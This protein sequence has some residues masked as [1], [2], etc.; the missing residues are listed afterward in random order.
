MAYSI[1]KSIEIQCSKALK[2]I[3][4]KTEALRK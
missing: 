4:S 3:S 1:A 2:E